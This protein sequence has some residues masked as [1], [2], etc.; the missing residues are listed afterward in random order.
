MTTYCANKTIKALN[1]HVNSLVKHF[2][3]DSIVCATQLSKIK[4]YFWYFNVI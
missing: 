3:C 2:V 4:Y 1:N